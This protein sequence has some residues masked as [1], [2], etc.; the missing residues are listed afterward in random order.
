MTHKDGLPMETRSGPAKTSGVYTRFHAF[1]KL[2]F[3]KA[4]FMSRPFCNVFSASV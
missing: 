2:L 1:R 4:P 3:Q